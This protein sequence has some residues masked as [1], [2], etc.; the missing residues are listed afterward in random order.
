MSRCIFHLVAIFLT[1]IVTM[2]CAGKGGGPLTPEQ[3]D[4]TANSAVQKT[5]THLWGLYDVYI[6][7]ETR[8]VEAIPNRS[9]MFAVN[10]TQFVNNPV[11]NLSFNIHGTPVTSSYIDVDIDV[12]IRHPFPGMTQYNGYDVRGIFLGA[13]S[14][15]MK[16]NSDLKYAMYGGTDQVMYDY[17]DKGTEFYIDPYGDALVGMPDGYTRWWNPTE[18]SNP[19]L[20]GYTQGALATPKYQNQITATLNPYKYYADGLNP[21]ADLWTWL[22]TKSNA[23]KFGRFSAGLKNTRNYYLRFPAPTPAVKFGYAILAN[24][25]SADPADHPSNALEA[26]SV[27]TVSTSDIYY[28]DASNNGGNLKLDISVYNW[29]TVM[30]E[31]MNIWLE[32][33]VLANPYK[34]SASEMTPVGS[35]LNFSTYHVEIP[36][37]NV[38]MPEGNEY[39]VIVEQPTENYKNDFGVPNG[40]GD[41]PLAAFFRFDLEIIACPK[42]KVTGIDTDGMGG[43]VVPKG[44]VSGIKI[45]GSGFQGPNCQVKFI[46]PDYPTNDV[47]ATNVV[48]NSLTLITCDADF[49]G[50]PSN[51]YDVQV[52]NNCGQSATAL[53]LLEC[54]FEIRYFTGSPIGEGVIPTYPADYKFAID[55]ACRPNDGAFYLAWAYDMNLS[56]VKDGYVARYNTTGTTMLNTYLCDNAWPSDPI[57]FKYNR[58]SLDAGTVN[59]K[60]GWAATVHPVQ[61]FGTDE[62]GTAGANDSWGFWFGYPY[63]WTHNSVYC[64]T[65]HVYSYAALN[66]FG[67]HY[68]TNWRHGDNGNWDNAACSYGLY[69]VPNDFDYAENTEDF[70]IWQTKQIALAMGKTDTVFFN[71]VTRSPHINGY[72]NW[73]WNAYNGVSFGTTGTNNGEISEWTL[74]VTTQMRLT[75]PVDMTMRIANERL[76]VLDEP[77]N[78]FLRIQSFT[79]AGAFVATS[80]EIAASKFGATKVLKFDYNDFNDC[81]YVLLNNNKLIAFKDYTI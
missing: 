65:G 15:V 66:Y 58:V 53:D 64:G 22:T 20:F 32:S 40:A 44:P 48:A 45:F 59:G 52:I 13:G 27:S 36:A 74:D 1:F 6:D 51:L 38:T 14:K 2:G 11:S 10:V 50:K 7:I 34:L 67:Y 69:E 39:W 19:G 18:F 28:V 76:Y 73:Q 3:P 57:F 8:T 5:Q 41:D 47:I 62:T 12:S 61:H 63:T 75:G 25:K 79:T 9:G 35:G 26:I 43:K 30:L 55:V 49:T 4:L 17:N 33:T 23:N 46:A 56:Q 77:K 37:D 70:P 31:N 80:G 29:S 72:T 16:Y 21:G 78:G 68:R 54:V 71:L 81:I 42:V 60:H 24:W